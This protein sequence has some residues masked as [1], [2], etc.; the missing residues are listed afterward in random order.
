[1]VTIVSVAKLLCDWP[2]YC[3]A[4]NAPAEAEK[5]LQ[6][7]SA[8]AENPLADYALLR[9]GQA[10]AEQSKFAE[11]SQAFEQM[12]AKFPKSEHLATAQL[13]SGQM[14]FR[15]GQYPEA[16]ERFKAVLQSKGNAGA[17][18]AHLLAMTL[19]RTPDAAKAISMLEE[20]LKWADKTP[21]ALQLRMDLADALLQR[22]TASRRSATTV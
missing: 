1:M 4:R 17:E 19:Q 15:N 16:A 8:S 5:L 7:S 14:Y 6:K 3:C 18:A 13:S 22:S 20:T 12:V 11:A 21:T 10:L 9:L 2:M